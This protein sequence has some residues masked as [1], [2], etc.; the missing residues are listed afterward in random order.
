MQLDQKRGYMNYSDIKK[1]R[2]VASVFGGIVTGLA[3]TPLAASAQTLNPCP[4]IYYEPPFNSNVLV[5]EGCPPNAISQ[6][7][8]VNQ[9]TAPQGVTLG[10]PGLPPETGAQVAPTPGQEGVQIYET[11]PGT[12]NPPGTALTPPIQPPLPENRSDAV[13]YVQPAND[14]ADVRLMNNTNIAIAYEVTGETDQRMLPAGEMVLLRNLSL[15]ASIAV[16]R[17]DDGFVELMPLVAEGGVLEVGIDEDVNPL[18]PNQGFIRI[19][20]DGQVFLN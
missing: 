8:G 17:D 2:L 7:L 20:P 18:D 3:V 9:E 15:P 11:T 10:T 12:T 5:P 1:T 6:Q 4:R 14:S 19:Q 13:A 16:W